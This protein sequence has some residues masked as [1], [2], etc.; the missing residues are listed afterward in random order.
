MFDLPV[1][2]KK[3]R[4][5]YTRFRKY[6]LDDGFDMLQYSIYSR[7][8]NCPD[9]AVKH[10]GRIQENVPSKGNIRI[11]Q[12]TERQYS[13]MKFVVGKPTPKEKM[14]LNDQLSYF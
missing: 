10:V 7:I 12:V 14:K 9:I 6:L 2:K 4:K 3:E 13:Q 11:L 8:C 1:V 5:A